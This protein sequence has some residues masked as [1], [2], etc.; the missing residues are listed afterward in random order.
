MSYHVFTLAEKKGQGDAMRKVG[1]TGLCAAKEWIDN[2]YANKRPQEEFS[3][4]R[5]IESC[6]R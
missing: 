6:V 2:Y 3:W 1:I 5:S 4:T